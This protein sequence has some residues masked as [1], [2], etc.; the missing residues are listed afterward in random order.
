LEIKPLQIFNYARFFIKANGNS[1]FP[2]LHSN[3]IVYY[4]KINLKKIKLND[5][6]LVNSN[7]DKYFTHRVVYKT[8]KYVITKGDNAIKSDGKIFPKQIV[9]KAYQIKR[10]GKIFSLESLYLIQSSLYFQ[11]IIKIKQIFEKKGVDFVFLKGLPLHLCYEGAH[12]RR[13]YLDCDVLVNKK[14]FQRAEKVLFQLGYKK[15]DSSLS[16]V[17]KK[18]KNK[19][20]EEAYFKK[21]N[22]FFIVFD[23]HLEPAF[24]MTQ[25]GNLEALYQQKFID[26]L[27]KELLKNKRKIFINKESF[28]ILSSENLILYLAL[29]FFHHNYEGIFRLEFIDKIIKKE[30]LS[31]TSFNQLTRII[32]NYQLQ[33]FVYPSFI[34]LKKYYR[35]P[36]P[37]LFLETIRPT[38]YFTLNLGSKTYHQGSVFDDEPRIQ[39]GVTRFKN[40]FFLSPRPW[41]IKICILANPQVIYSIFLVAWKQI[42]GSFSAL[43]QKS[44]H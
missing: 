13:I 38:N 3:D 35:T 23:L 21:I 4:K 10:S 29:H 9:G 15:T 31:F 42:L 11:E 19:Q 7:K 37:R 26:K 36:I 32:K 41:W 30:N 12:P 8:K 16:G 33:N 22:N 18:I 2:I 20:I 17:Q 14:D 28:F 27:T 5:L 39:A 25:L 44:V 1:M 24:M 34:L 43:S 6:I 40:L